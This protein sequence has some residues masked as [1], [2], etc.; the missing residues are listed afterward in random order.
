VNA[1]DG[2]YNTYGNPFIMNCI[3]WGNGGYDLSN[4][5]ATYSVI[6]TGELV[7]EGNISVDPMFVG[8]GDYHL[9][10]GSPCIDAGS[11]S[12]LALPDTD[13]DG[14][15]RIIGYAVD[16]G[17]YESQVPLNRPPVGD[18]GSDQIVQCACQTPGGTKV[19]LDG[20]G[21]YDPDGDLLTYTWTGQFAESPASGPTTTVTLDPGCLGTYPIILVVNDGN[22]DSEPDTVQITVVDTT[23]PTIICPETITVEAQSPSG[24][25]S[26]DPDILTFLTEVSASDKCDPSPETTD[27]APVEFPLGDTIVTFSST[28]AQNNSSSCQATVMVQ[29]T[30]PP[31][32]S[33]HAPEPYGLYPV[34]SL[35]LDFSAYDLVSG[36]IEPPALSG[37]LTDAAGFSG[38]VVPGDVPGAGVY[39]L[40]VCAEDEAENYAESEPVFFVIYDPEGGFVTGGGW[41]ESPEGA[42]RPDPSLTG[43]ANFGFV[44]KYKKGAATPTG[45]TEFVFKAGDLNFHS[46]SYDWLVVTGSNYARFKGTGIINGYGEYRFMLWAGDNPDTF[47]IRIWEEDDVGSEFDVYD[48]G[49]DQDIMGGNIIIHTN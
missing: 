7:G 37:T 5:S 19:T 21:S 41:I 38:P 32:I 3:L 17:A 14:N 1:V 20:S 23:P 31:E 47:R 33:I 6:G 45:N 22:V 24:V 43:K 27:D 46:S 16:M 28:D 15:P 9:Q 8:D 39:T 10:D 25:P 30:T 4:A 49:F 11:N 42:Y 44:S 36:N 48:N 13:K 12:A 18:A 35:A 26:S 2:L 29:D 40:V 34:G